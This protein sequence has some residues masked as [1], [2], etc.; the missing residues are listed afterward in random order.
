MDQ[1]YTPGS[2]SEEL[3]G[4]REK[5]ISRYR[6]ADFVWRGAMDL[7]NNGNLRF[8]VGYFTSHFKRLL[9]KN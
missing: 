3:G 5:G 9:F 1:P 8:L 2:E 7:F 4:K 6:S